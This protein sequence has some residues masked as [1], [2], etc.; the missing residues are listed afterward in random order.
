[1]AICVFCGDL[2]SESRCPRCFKD[3]EREVEASTVAAIVAG[4]RKMQVVGKL[5]PRLPPLA[6]RE[7]VADWIE[8]GAWKR[9]GEEGQK[10]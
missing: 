7:G 9:P 10:P 8:S 2:L 6:V 5:D 3:I 4:L 1:M